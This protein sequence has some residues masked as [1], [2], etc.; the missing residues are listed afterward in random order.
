MHVV[1]ARHVVR[2]GRNSLH[3]VLGWAVLPRRRSAVHDMPGRDRD[4]RPR[5]FGLRRDV[6]RVSRRHVRGHRRQSVRRVR[7]RGHDVH[8]VL[9]WPEVA[10]GRARLH[11]D[12]TRAR[13]SA[14][15]TAA[16]LRGPLLHQHKGLLLFRVQE[17][18]MGQVRRGR[19]MLGLLRLCRLL[20]LSDAEAS[21]RMWEL[22][23]WLVHGRPERVHELLENVSTRNVVRRRCHRVHGLRGRH[24]LR[25]VLGQFLRGLSGREK[26][27]RGRQHRVCGG[28][29]VVRGG[30]IL[31]HR[32][33]MR[34][35]RRRSNHMRGV[36]RRKVLARGRDHVSVVRRRQDDVLGRPV[37]V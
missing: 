27:V 32:H 30:Q 11:A 18:S 19:G 8:G 3:T 23:R 24:V 7:R 16:A 13:V 15:T 36:R 33:G 29:R 10:R 35:V 6:H 31:R 12:R 9:Q 2:G 21:R 14:R 20:G 17:H 37:G 5:Q 34:S 25:H 4:V 28:V 22:C 1:S 26:H